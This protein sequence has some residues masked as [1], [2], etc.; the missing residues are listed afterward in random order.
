MGV[1]R[2][3]DIRPCSDRALQNLVV[4]FVIGHS[5]DTL[6]RGD[7][8][9]D[10]AQMAVHLGNLLPAAVKLVADDAEGFVNDR[11]GDRQ[12]DFSD[13]CHLENRQR[14]STEHEG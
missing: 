1:S 12:F 11:L 3:N 6:H 4:V 2:N 7:D 13:L 5:I 10:C 9:A 14:L 8:T